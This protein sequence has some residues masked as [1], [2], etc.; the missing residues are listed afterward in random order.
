MWVHGWLSDSTRTLSIC[1]L[2]IYFSNF[3]NAG[4]VAFSKRELG[5]GAEPAFGMG[6][7]MIRQLKIRSIDWSIDWLID[8]SI[9]W[10]IVL[11]IGRRSID[12]LIDCFADCW[13]IDWLLSWL[14]DCLIAW[15]WFDCSKSIDSL[16]CVW[17]HFFM[18]H[19][20]IFAF[21]SAFG[22][23]K[24]RLRHSNELRVAS[25]RWMDVL[26]LALNSLFLSP[27]KFNQSSFL[28][29]PI[30]NR[31]SNCSAT[32]TAIATAIATEIG[33]TKERD[34]LRG[35]FVH[36]QSSAALNCILMSHLLSFKGSLQLCR[37]PTR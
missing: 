29:E 14:I 35:L 1:L 12:W 26:S 28:R 19:E 30:L 6:E 37:Y 8:W 11:L 33:Q 18:L 10:L 15:V 32:A 4:K 16:I 7:R 3:G 17:L 9:D 13:S 36:F 27:E 24:Y 21:F 23:T 20:M 34:E 31:S 22:T 5:G 25:Y 2:L